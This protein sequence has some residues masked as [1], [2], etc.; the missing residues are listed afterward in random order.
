MRI[1]IT[2]ASGYIGGTITQTLIKAGHEVIGLAKTEKDAE[3]ITALGA[4]AHSG[5]LADFDGL[6]RGIEMADGVI[7]TAFGIADWSQLEK[8]MILERQAVEAMISALAGTGHPFVYTSGA[9]VYDDTGNDVVD[10]TAS[11]TATGAVGM[12]AGIEQIVLKAKD[13]NV[14]TSVIRPGMVY[15]K[16]GSAVVLMMAGLVRQAG[17]PHT[18][19]DGSNVWSVVHVKDLA[20]LYMRALEKSEAGMIYHA[21]GDEVSMLD[22]ASAM[23]R[24]LK[25]SGSPSIWPVEEAEVV[26]GPLAKGLTINKRISSARA[27]EVLDWRP[28]HPGMIEEIETGSYPKALN[29]VSE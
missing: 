25:L 22:I 4:S 5:D 19:G 28:S 29:E 26:I 24:T 14:R 7:H 27:R 9:G 23:A 3:V 17:G 18:I 12:R 15:G 8:A 1:F 2:G 6:K 21:A 10:E 11:P 16:G 13:Q 20:D